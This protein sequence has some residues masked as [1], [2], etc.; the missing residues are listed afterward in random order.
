MSQKPTV[1]VRIRKVSLQ[2]HPQSDVE[3]EAWSTEF[4]VDELTISL[5]ETKACF[6]MLA[7][8][9]KRVRMEDLRN[10]GRGVLRGLYEEQARYKM[11]RMPVFR[12]PPIFAV[13]LK[14]LDP[15]LKRELAKLDRWTKDYVMKAAI[16][17]IFEHIDRRFYYLSVKPVL[18]W[19][20]EE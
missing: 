17:R 14:H 9:T 11:Y 2:P 19:R 10:Q 8:L 13:H 15:L 4:L 20:L 6:C 5:L 18:D 16:G 7:G 1:K 12:P 3:K